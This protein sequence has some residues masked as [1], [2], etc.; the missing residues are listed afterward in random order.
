MSFLTLK[1]GL[2]TRTVITVLGHFPTLAEKTT[3]N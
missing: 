1:W 3:S 2:K